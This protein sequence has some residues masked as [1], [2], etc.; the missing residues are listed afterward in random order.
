MSIEEQ[1]VNPSHNSLIYC[2]ESRRLLDAFGDN[3]HQLLLLHEQQ[4]VAIT[5]GDP[6]CDRFDLL[7][8]LANEG[9]QQA[10]YLY[11]QHLENHGC[12]K[13]YDIYKS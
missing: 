7:I 6:D 10:K 12:S 9:K 11:L 8:H 5:S 2:E 1:V 3:V 13:S 4:F